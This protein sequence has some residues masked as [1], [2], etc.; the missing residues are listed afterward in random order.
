MAPSG[1]P[2]WARLLVSLGTGLGV[3][4]LVALVLTLLDLYQSGHGQQP[5]GRPWLDVEALGVHLGR[6]D[7]LFLAAAVLGVGLTWRKTA[8]GA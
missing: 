5:L 6:A 8:S 3:G 4:L 7:V 2:W 1:R